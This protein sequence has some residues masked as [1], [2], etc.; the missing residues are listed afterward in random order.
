VTKKERYFQVTAVRGQ[1][2][3]QQ[4]FYDSH[5]KKSATLACCGCGLVHDIIGFAWA[6][7]RKNGRIVGYRRIKGGKVSLRFRLNNRATAARRRNKKFKAVSAAIKK[8][9]K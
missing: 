1:F 5:P 8:G 6:P 2:S 9:S 3:D 4:L 7:V